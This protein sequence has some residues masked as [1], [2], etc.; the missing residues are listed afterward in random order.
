MEGQ[1][2]ERFPASSS[3]RPGTQAERAS[4]ALK[5]FVRNSLDLFYQDL[6]LRCRQRPA[7][8][9]S[10]HFLAPYLIWQDDTLTPY[11]PRG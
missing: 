5:A 11:G 7:G 8:G 2:L 1:K 9:L 4:Q 10:C 6:D 3:Q